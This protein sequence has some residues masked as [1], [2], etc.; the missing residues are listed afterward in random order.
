MV[1]VEL[2]AEDTDRLE[3]HLNSS[4]VIPT[5][6]LASGINYSRTVRDK[7]DPRRFLLIQQW[8]SEEQP[9]S[10]I[11]WRS[12]RGDLAQLRTMLTADPAVSHLS[13]VNLTTLPAQAR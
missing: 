4:D 3:Q 6:H 11:A 10:Y 5:T 7:N 12:E 9:Q 1:V 2:L 8:N 13:L